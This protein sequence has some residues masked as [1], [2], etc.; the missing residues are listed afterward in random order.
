M[1]FELTKA[2]MDA[3]L[4]SMEDQDQ[5]SYFDTREGSLVNGDPFEGAAA[6]PGAEE[7][8]FLALPRWEPS[9]GF[10][11]M[12]RFAAS[13][14]NP[15][16]REELSSALNRGKGVFR[17]FKDVLGRHP[18][19]GRRWF[20]FKEQEMRKVI[21]NWYNALRERWGLEQIGLEPEETGELVLEDF[22]I[23]PA[24]PADREPA[25]E[26]HRRCLE[27]FLDFAKQ[28]EIL[29]LPGQT[30]AVGAVGAFGA[31][32]AFLG[33]SA[34]RWTFPGSLSLV[35]EAGDGEFAAYISAVLREA[36]L[37]ITA[38]EVRPEYR[39]LGLG[40]TLLTRLAALAADGSA[41]NL[42]LDLPA[43]SGEFS[44]VLLR[45]AFKPYLHRYSLKLAPEGLP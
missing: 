20:A 10:R 45:G 19:L 21:L 12:E 26:L 30:P 40:E 17:A 41:S 37:Y 3:I 7:E 16:V 36:S 4:F 33:E 11:L 34:A 18:E 22:H 29:E 31:A 25:E 13:C 1:Q 32:D 35:A 44:K 2:L 9:D 24:L 39:G 42:L 43:N 6:E 38:L 27:E 5:I 14:K 15:L 8:R 23:R 28:R